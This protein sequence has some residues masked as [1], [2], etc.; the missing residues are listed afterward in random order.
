MLTLDLQVQPLEFDEKV[1]LPMDLAQAFDRVGA[2]EAGAQ[3]L[4]AEEVHARRT[5]RAHTGPPQ[6][7]WAQGA[8]GRGGC[9]DGLRG[10]HCGVRSSGIIAVKVGTL[11]DKS[12]VQPTV[13]VWC[14]D[15]QPWVELPGMQVSLERE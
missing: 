2:A 7:I 13:E 6:R 3:D 9:G 5:E 14:V 12:A 10:W 1:T 4:G 15:R 8:E 11:D